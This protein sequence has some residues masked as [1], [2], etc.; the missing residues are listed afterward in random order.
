MLCSSPLESLGEAL[1]SAFSKRPIIIGVFEKPGLCADGLLLRRRSGEGSLLS[2]FG[3]SD[4]YQYLRKAG[5]VRCSSP[6]ERLGEAACFYKIFT[7]LS[8]DTPNLSLTLLTIFSLSSN[9]SL[10][11]AFPKFTNTKDCRSCTPASPLR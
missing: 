5:A 3:K 2:T 4:N 7:S 10:P 11:D 1:C 8:N 6:L 9:T